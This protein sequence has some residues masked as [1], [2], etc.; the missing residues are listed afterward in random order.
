MSN[1]SGLLKAPC[2]T[3]WCGRT[4]RRSWPR[5]S[6][7]CRG[8][9]SRNFANTCPAV[10]WRRASRASGARWHLARNVSLCTTVLSLF[11]Q[12]LFSCQ[13]R[14][15]RELDVEGQNAAVSFVQRFGSA[16]QLNVHFHVLVPE[17]LFA[18][19]SLGTSLEGF[20]LHANTRVHEHDRQGLEQL[21]RYGARGPLAYPRP[22]GRT[23]SLGPSFCAERSRST[24]RAA[25]R[26]RHPPPLT[27]AIPGASHRARSSSAPG[28]LLH[29]PAP[30]WTPAELNPI[31]AAL[32]E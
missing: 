2:C 21:C 26:S 22:K 31:D 18:A 4:S 6:G 1:S 3:R 16:L 32:A 20:S 28:Q 9:S 25:R 15:G 17:G 23:D 13:R 8:M 24:S 30:S 7:G 10:S 5:H 12:A 27:P 11:V 14:R 19:P 29:R